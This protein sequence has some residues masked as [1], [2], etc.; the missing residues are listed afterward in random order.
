MFPPSFMAQQSPNFLAP[1]TV[2]MEDNV[3]TDQEW[4]GG[5]FRMTQA[6]TFIVH[7]ISIYYDVTSTS[8]HQA[9][10]PGD[11]GPLLWLNPNTVLEQF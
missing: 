8:D 2:F 3:S 1:G 9:F 7:F 5:G 10:D 11:C 4:E 6:I